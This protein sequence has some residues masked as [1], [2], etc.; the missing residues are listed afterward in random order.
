MANY[1]INLDLTG[2]DVL[3]VG[4]GPVAARKVAG[5]VEAGA[6][7]HVVS[8]EFVS[9][10]E[11]RSDISRRPEPYTSKAIGTSRLVFACT[12]DGAANAR[13]AADARAAGAWCCIADDPPGSDFH[14]PAVLRRGDLTV[15]VGTGG[16]SP[17]LAAALRDRLESQFPHEL[18]ILVEELGRARQI[19][20]RKVNDRAARESVLTTLCAERSVELLTR[21]GREA[22]R[23]WFEDVLRDRLVAGPD[24]VQS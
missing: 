16:A 15:T 3:V 21:S 19:V 1:P 24:A 6:K 7:V 18:G 20:L 14:V 9:E 12:D 13:I 5:L 11:H 2:R 10:L 8:P 23:A 17:H 4:G 22:W